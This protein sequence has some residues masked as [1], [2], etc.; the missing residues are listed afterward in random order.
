MVAEPVSTRPT[1]D[2]A[3]MLAHQI[4][5]CNDAIKGY[6]IQLCNA[7][8]RFEAVKKSAS[9]LD[10]SQMKRT[11]AYK[12]QAADARWYAI[13]LEAELQRI[14]AGI[15][16]LM[17][18]NLFPSA[19]TREP[20]AFYYEKKGDHYRFLAECA[21]GDAK[22]KAVDVSMVSER[23]APMIQKVLKTVEAPQMQ[24]SDRIVDLPVVMQGQVPTI[25]TVQRTVEVPQVQFHDRVADVPV[26]MQ[27]QAPQERPA[28]AN[29]F[30]NDCDE[31]IPRWLNAVKGVIDSEDLPL[32]VCRETLLQNKIL[33]VIK[34][35]HVTKYLEM[36]A[37]T[38]EL[39]DDRKKLYER[40]VK[41][42]KEGQNDIYCITGEGIAVG[43]SRLFWEHPHRKGHARPTLWTNIPCTSPRSL[44]E[45]SRNRQ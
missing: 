5:G 31:L 28:E 12:Q 26:S 3:K 40:F 36:L 34:K 43:S 32:N 38:A 37:E 29:K 27:R 20:K 14:F 10:E 17:D 21:T 42:M 41:C 2:E 22:N 25:R 33:R 19:S 44:M 7:D 45:R 6:E 16:A 15:L 24:Y 11:K 8:G 39:N 4:A 9:E 13:V 35:N 30:L 23:Q 18:E 1:A